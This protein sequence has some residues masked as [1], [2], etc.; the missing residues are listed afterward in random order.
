MRQ[1]NFPPQKHLLTKMLSLW[2]KY[3]VGNNV[4]WGMECD[5]MPMQ[6]NPESSKVE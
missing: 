6:S 1:V 4:E 5:L 2:T 3:C